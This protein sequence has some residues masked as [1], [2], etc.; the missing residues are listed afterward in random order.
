M[1]Y[2]ALVD[3]HKVFRESLSLLLAQDPEFKADGVKPLLLDAVRLISHTHSAMK[4]FY[5]TFFY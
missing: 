2:L 3:D 5:H 4:R 1:I